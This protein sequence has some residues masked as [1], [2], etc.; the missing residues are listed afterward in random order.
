[1]PPEHPLELPDRVRRLLL[2]PLDSFEKLEIVIALHARGD[3]PLTLDALESR[4][5][6]PA[7]VLTMALDELIAA[8]IVERRAGSASVISPGCD[9]TALDELAASWSTSRTSVLEVMT[10]RAVERIRAS[11]ARAFADAFAL[12]RGHKSNDGDDD[13]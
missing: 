12:R 3:K 10:A 5:G 11:A 1:M 8:G 9:R 6:A 4:V 7:S 2:G 13:G